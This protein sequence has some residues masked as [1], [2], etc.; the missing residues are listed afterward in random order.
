MVQKAAFLMHLE[1]L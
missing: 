1:V